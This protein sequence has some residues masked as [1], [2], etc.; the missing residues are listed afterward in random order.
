MPIGSKAEVIRS[1]ELLDAPF[2]FMFSNY[3]NYK[4]HGLIIDVR[5]NWGGNVDSWII[6]KLLRRNWM[7][8]QTT[9]GS[10]FKNMQQRFCVV[11]TV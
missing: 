2:P 3:D 10:Q 4:K 6:E 7:F 9:N 8:W 11:K 1:E 5:R